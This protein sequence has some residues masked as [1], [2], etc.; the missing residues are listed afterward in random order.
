[1]PSWA[2]DYLAGL[3]ARAAGCDP[4]DFYL[5]PRTALG[6]AIQGRVEALVGVSDFE[7]DSPRSRPALILRYLETLRRSGALGAGFTVLDVACGDAVVLWQIRRKHPESECRGIDLHK[8]GFPAHARAQAEGVSLHRIFIQHLFATPPPRPFDVVLMLNTYRGW[9]N[10]DLRPHEAELP[11]QADAWF[12]A[13]AR[14]AIVTARPRQV[15]A[16][17]RKGFAVRRLGAGEGGSRMVGFS[18]QA[19]PPA[20]AR[21]RLDAWLDRLR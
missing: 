11:A 8:D 7:V 6:D 15:A 16:L 1:M 2:A 18:R 12:E 19:Q 13:A 17:R 10:A 21:D 9:E 3:E 4:A 14:Y 5:W 20:S